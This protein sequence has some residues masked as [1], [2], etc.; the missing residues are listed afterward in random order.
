MIKYCI[1]TN[2]ILDLCYRYYPP[3]IF[4]N[5]WNDLEASVLSRHIG[6]LISEHIYEEVNNKV[7]LMQY[8]AAILSQFVQ[9]FN[10]SIIPKKD[11]KKDLSDLQAELLDITKLSSSISRNEDDLSNICVAKNE[12]A[13]VITAEQGSQL[14]ITDSSYKRLKIPDTCEHYNIKCQ[15]WLPLFKYIGL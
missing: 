1:D 5:V 4:K 7:I 6:F 10:V 3:S 11:Y 2:A 8:D 13:T 15:N 14:K 12:N 9:T